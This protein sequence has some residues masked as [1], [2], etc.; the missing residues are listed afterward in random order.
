M[1]GNVLLVLL[2]RFDQ[3]RLYTQRLFVYEWSSIREQKTTVGE[4]MRTTNLKATHANLGIENYKQP[5]DIP[6]VFFYKQFTIY[7]YFSHNDMVMV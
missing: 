5:N 7:G 2:A 6:R 3:K 1:N 4:E